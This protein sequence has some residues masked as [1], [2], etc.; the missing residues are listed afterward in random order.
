MTF[1]YTPDVDTK[2]HE[3]GAI[4]L[5]CKPYQSHEKGLPEWIKN[6]SD[7]YARQGDDADQ[8]VIVVV[9]RTGDKRHDASISCLDFGGMTTE[10]IENDFRAWADP[11]AAKRAPGTGIIQGG[12]GNGG[13]CYMTQMF[14]Q[15]SLL[16]TVRDGVGSKYG[17]DVGSVRFGYIPDR[18][19][20][21]GFAVSNL[22]VELSEALGAIGSS[23]KAL[24]PEALLALDRAPGLTLVSGVGPKGF[25]SKALKS[26]IASLTDHPQMIQTLQYCRVFLVVDNE[27]PQALQ[28]PKIP[29]MPGEEKPRDFPIPEKL[30][31]PLTED[32]I[33]TVPPGGQPGKLMLM[34]SEKSMRTYRKNRHNVVY[35]AKTGF[36]GYV[37][38]G[39]LDVQSPFRDRIY[40]ECHLDSLEPFKQNDRGPLADSPLTRAVQKF[41]ALQ[42]EAYAKEFEARD[43]RRYDQ[44]EKNALSKMNEALDRWKNKFLAEMFRG[45]FGGGGRQPEPPLPTGKVHTIQLA[46]SHNKAGLGVPFQPTLR[47]FDK[48]GRRIRATP[49]RW[50]SED[51]NVAMVDEELG[52]INTFSVGETIIYAETL[53]GKVKSNRVPLE[54]VHLKS[55]TLDPET[56]E[57]PAGSRRSITGNCE[58]LSGDITH[59]VYLVWTESNSAVARVSSS[60]NVYA[61]S[62]G[63][64]EVVAADDHCEAKK[65]CTITV[66]PAVGEDAGG[67]NKGS[68]SGRGFPRILIS[69]VVVDPETHEHVTFSREDPPVWQRPQDVDRDIWWINSAAPFAR[70]YLDPQRYGYTS[71][72]WRMYH[73]ER[74]IEIMV[75][76]AMVSGPGDKEMLSV[77]DWILKWGAQAAEIQSN[78]AAALSS[79]ISTGELPEE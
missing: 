28:L 44:E 47:F 36:V 55:I 67:K 52:V 27:A 2:V 12:H 14:E 65:R 26:L 49:Y 35:F 8:R 64:T 16:H 62:E 48:H 3:E 60:G 5:I 46:I 73:L 15:Y 4:R 13:K 72:E 20:G 43:R 59:D 70:M 50:V 61:F 40:G 76:I 37:A 41:I 77:G 10:Q 24:P 11:E 29:T 19:N 6:S 30:K 34:T 75:Q 45:M 18:Q 17:V 22:R 1:K 58:L 23:L 39:E 31:D 71:R 56:I 78:A 66:V 51:T 42:I 68:K 38:V 25:S 9:I 32:V 21:R 53:D 54:V 7:V 69:E 33:A 57:L 79:F 74:Y 63:S